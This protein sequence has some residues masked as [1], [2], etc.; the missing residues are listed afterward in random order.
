M[1]NILIYGFGLILELKEVNGLLMYMCVLI[2]L[3]WC[4]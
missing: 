2:F 4:Y 3:Y 1:K